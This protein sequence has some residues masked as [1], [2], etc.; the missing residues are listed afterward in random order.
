[1]TA[2]RHAPDEPREPDDGNGSLT[3]ADVNG[4][5]VAAVLAGDARAVADCLADGADP[6]TPG[7]DGLPLL[8]AAV[9]GF[10]HASAGALTDGGADPDVVL[11][12]GTTPLLRAVDLGSPALV[13]ATLGTDPRLRI[14]GSERQRLLDL[15]RHW[16]ETGAAAELRRRTGDL[17]PV[18]RRMVE[19]EYTDIEELTLGGLTVRAGHSGVLSDLEREFGVL[20]PVAELVARAVPYPD[21]LDA[22]WSAAR[23]AL[24]CRRNPR[25]W[26]ELAA[27]RRHPDPVHR[28]LLADVLR[29]RRFLAA[30][31]GRPDTAKDADFLARWARDE[32]DGEVLAAVLEVYTDADHPGQEAIG[33]RHADHP[34]PRVRR[35]VPYCLPPTGPAGTVLLGLARDSDAGVRH[36]VAEVLGRSPDPAAVRESL[37]ALLRDPDPA[38]RVR[39]AA[40]LAG[41]R[42]RTAAVMEALVALLD[43]EDQ[44]LRLEAACALAVRDDPRTD[45]AYER[46]GPLGPGFEEDHRVSAHWHYRFRNRPGGS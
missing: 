5:L 44:S 46:V 29:F 41:S 45:A 24:A 9:R 43:E 14:A 40:S 34:D 22:N 28:R 8:C 21:P 18:T 7:P 42:D 33:L 25:D 37:L 38:V 23:H 11:P 31:V 39:A 36:V 32:P 2:P 4:R 26:S 6:H 35:V 16:H 12:D 19:E 27:L 13:G 10:D 30:H 15:A 3:A 17:G 1:M 20:P